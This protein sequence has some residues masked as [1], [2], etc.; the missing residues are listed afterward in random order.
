VFVELYGDHGKT[1]ERP[2]D[3]G[4]EAFERAGVEEFG[5]D[6]LDLGELQRLRVGHDGSGWAPGWFLIKIVVRSEWASVVLFVW[7]V[8]RYC[9][10]STEK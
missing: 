10:R 3:V 4:K 6:S 7:P 5:I 1:G 8:V 2:L 9:G